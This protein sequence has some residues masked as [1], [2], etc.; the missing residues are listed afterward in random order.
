MMY[1]RMISMLGAVLTAVLL[2]GGCPAAIDTVDTAD[3]T[4]TVGQDNPQQGV[5]APLP[6]YDGEWRILDQL[7]GF[8]FCILV[9][10]DTVVGWDG[11]WIGD[12]ESR[13]VFS[14]Q[15]ASFLGDR[16]FWTFTVSGPDAAMNVSLDL[17]AQDDG[18]LAGSMTTS[19]IGDPLGVTGSV[20]LLPR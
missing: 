18:S 19:P 5:Q 4:N 10:S 1:T 2:L 7:T 14:N 8:Q 15:P 3:T 20:L 17:Q 6:A 16:V 13:R 11:G 9:A 12:Y